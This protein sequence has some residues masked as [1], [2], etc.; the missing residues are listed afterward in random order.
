[1]KH[2]I[3][4]LALLLAIGMMCVLCIGCDNNPGNTDKPGGNKPG[5]TTTQGTTQ[6]PEDTAPVTQYG[7]YTTEG[8]AQTLQE[9]YAEQTQQSVVS[10]ASG[11][12]YSEE[13]LANVYKIADHIANY[14]AYVEEY[15]VQEQLDELYKETGFTLDFGFGS[16]LFKH[17]LDTTGETFDYS[18]RMT[19]I[20]SNPQVGA[21]QT[22]TINAA[23]KA[24]EN[25]VKD[26]Q[27]GI[28]IHQIKASGFSVKR[29]ADA[30]L[31]FALGSY[32]TMADLSNVQR[33]GDTIS[34]TVTFRIVDFY[35]WDE[36][37]TEP[38]FTSYLEKLDEG[39]R[40]LLA[41][42]IDL[43]TLEGFCQADI[44]QLHRAGFAQNYLVQ[45][46]VV[47]N[48]TWTAGQTFAQATVTPA[49]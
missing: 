31:Y 5:N 9:L 14:E 47:Y 13:K 23:M 46:T 26:G 39:Y 33:T 48:V 3:R 10:F 11:S 1:M 38:E 15:G 20:L 8:A 43:P 40:T 7:N 22:T 45:G 30:E 41:E 21:A 42:M 37:Y 25:L 19:E 12:S 17:Y 2:T 28:S 18:G 32:Q 34:A 27:S 4:I 44:A 29:S 6:A 49:Q 24:A 36:N 16:E 35:S